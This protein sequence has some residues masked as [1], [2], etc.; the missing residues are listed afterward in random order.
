MQSAIRTRWRTERVKHYADYF[1][2]FAEDLFKSLS[3]PVLLTN[4][5]DMTLKLEGWLRLVREVSAEDRAN[6]PGRA[7]A[8]SGPSYEAQG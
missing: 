7:W 4:R 8:P 5:R 3:D 1:V 6:P 2:M